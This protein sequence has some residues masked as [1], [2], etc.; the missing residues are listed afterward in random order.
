MCS[1]ETKIENSTKVTKAADQTIYA[2]WKEKPS[3]SGGGGGGCQC[4][5]Q[6][7][8]CN[9]GACYYAPTKK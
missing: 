5:A 3:P 2:H 9:C 6:S 8:C 1:N 7:Y 4:Y